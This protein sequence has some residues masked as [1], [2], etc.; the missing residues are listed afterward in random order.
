M[1]QLAEKIKIDFLKDKNSFPIEKTLNTNVIEILI[2]F[3]KKKKALNR[4]PI[5]LCEFLDVLALIASEKGAVVDRLVEI[6]IIEIAS[7]LLWHEHSEAKKSA[8]TILSNIALTS[9]EYREQIIE[10]EYE[11]I[12][13]FLLSKKIKKISESLKT[14]LSLL[15][16]ALFRGPPYQS[17]QTVNQS[18]WSSSHSYPFR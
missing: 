18:F 10:E 2:K 16:M 4:T 12:L 14:H 11:N 8:L 1:I 3:I 15:L 6:R 5:G 17:S 13:E 7:D 9:F